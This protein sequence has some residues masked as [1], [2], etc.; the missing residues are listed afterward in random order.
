MSREIS[1]DF[2]TLKSFLK[3]YSLIDLSSN[4]DFLRIL[5]Q[6]HKKYFAFLTIVAELTELS[7]N[8]ELKPTISSKQLSFLTES[9]SDI[10]NSIFVMTHG[11][12]KASRMMLRS[13]IETFNKAFNLDD[14]PNIDREKSVFAIFDGIRGLDFFQGEPKKGILESIHQDYKTLCQDTHTATELNM[15]QI[16]ALKYF[17]TFALE[18]ASK[19]SEIVMRLVSNYNILLALKYNFHFHQMHHKNRENILENIQRQF[20]PLILGIEI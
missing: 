12:Y 8:K 11:S 3:S 18:E 20:R 16:T 15:A 19:L 10:G 9:C 13:S 7:K 14:V 1:E 4:K 2:F 5:S 17:P 6:Q